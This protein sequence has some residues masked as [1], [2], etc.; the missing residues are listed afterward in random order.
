M[1]LVLGTAWQRSLERRRGSLHLVAGTQHPSACAMRCA[2]LPAAVRSRP[3]LRAAAHIAMMGTPPATRLGCVDVGVRIFLFASVTITLGCAHP[4]AAI[5]GPP[6]DHT[7]SEWIDLQPGW[8]VRVIT[9]VVAGG[10]YLVKTTPILGQTTDG[11]ASE[12]RSPSATNAIVVSANSNLIGYGVS[13]YKVKPRREGGVRVVFDSAEMHEKELVKRS[14]KP[15][16]LPFQFTKT[17]RCVRILHL[18]RG[19]HDHNAAILAANSLSALEGLTRE[20]ESRPAACQAG[21]DASCSWIPPGIAVIP[22]SWRASDRQGQW[23]PAF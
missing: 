3:Q 16:D 8:R 20:V 22:E 12:R 4:K 18:S 23:Q 11:E 2:Y 10:G 9:P 15:I 13:L 19:T 7:S 14:R 5:P 17:A 1:F 21:T 6:V